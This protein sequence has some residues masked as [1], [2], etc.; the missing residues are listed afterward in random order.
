VVFPF[1]GRRNPANPA[2]SQYRRLAIHTSHYM[3]SQIAAMIAGLISVPILTR[4][5]TRE[6][7]GRLSLL[8]LAV[9][10]FTSF[11]RLGIPQSITRYLPEYGKSGRE[12]AHHYVSSVFLFSVASS[13]LI[14]LAISGA[15][16][17]SKGS[18]W[19]PWSIYISLFGVLLCN[20]VLLSTLSEVY[21]AQQR[22]LFTSMIGIIS[23]YSTL[24]ASLLFF[25]LVSRSL[26]SFLAGKASIQ[27]ILICAFV[28]P[29]FRR[30]FIRFQKIDFSIVRQAI[31]YGLP[32]SLATAG[33]FF[34]AYGDRYVIQ[35]LMSTVEV[36]R[37][38]LPYDIV[39]QAE[40]ALTTP[41]RMA[42]VPLVFTMMLNDGPEKASAFLSQVV[43]GVLL[44]II[45]MIFGLSF[46]AKDIVVLLG[47]NKY[48][49][50]SPLLPILSAGILLGGINF[51][52]T[53]GLSFQKRT[54]IIAY[55]TIGS[56]IFN[57]L[58]NLVLIPLMGIFGSAWA[59]LISYL[60]HLLISY[61]LSARYLRIRFHPIS[62]MKSLAAATV[63]VAALFALDTFLPKG[64]YGLLCKLPLAVAVYGA[65]ICALDKEVRAVASRIFRRVPLLP[66]ESA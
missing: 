33:G 22:S 37:Y 29:L 31:R 45:P 27:T 17:L 2:M 21:R 52:L 47:S 3:M 44:L 19:D 65:A 56:G 10:F 58:M 38:S 35:G 23:R 61:R 53:T 36:A 48:A 25:F 6:D 18:R 50:S 12:S 64:S 49:D 54:D 14:A 7:Y 24:A 62:L 59:T 66:S 26:V 51:L 39:Q 9:S 34:I 11:A 32:L 13:T 15:G 4:I 40:T 43:R 55:M 41:L 16:L 30:G 63:M 57:V 60:L 42:I 46:L 1:S 20:E 5:L 8:L 28:I